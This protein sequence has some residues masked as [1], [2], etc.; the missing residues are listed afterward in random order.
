MKSVTQRRKCSEIINNKSEDK[1]IISLANNKSKDKLISLSE[2]AFFKVVVGRELFFI[3]GQLRRVKRGK[4]TRTLRETNRSKEP[5][6][7]SH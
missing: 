4:E 2:Y 5:E 1:I 6:K 7:F 3:M